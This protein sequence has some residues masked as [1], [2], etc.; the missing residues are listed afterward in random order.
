M[1]Y[2]ER[3][4]Y[5]RQ[6]RHMTQA[7]LGLACGFMNRGDVRIAQYEGATRHPRDSVNRKLADALHVDPQVL[8]WDTDDDNANLYYQL[9]WIQLSETEPISGFQ[10]IREYMEEYNEE[11]D[12]LLNRLEM[13]EV[14]TEQ[15]IDYLLNSEPILL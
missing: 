1:T 2:G 10:T 8:Y 3:L 13:A 14:N 6:L 12:L 4:K 5:V 7:E 11:M 15:Y 9:L